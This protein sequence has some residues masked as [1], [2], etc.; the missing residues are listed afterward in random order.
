[1]VM[2]LLPSAVQ[3]AW[4]PVGRFGASPCWAPCSSTVVSLSGSEPPAGRSTGPPPGW[5]E[6]VSREPGAPRSLW[7]SSCGC[8]AGSVLSTAVPLHPAHREVALD[9]RPRAHTDSDGARHGRSQYERGDDSDGPHDGA[10][11][12]GSGSPAPASGSSSSGAK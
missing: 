3:P 9:V 2:V 4:S 6:P 7:G 10:S 11:S 5:S 8:A 12:R 1:M